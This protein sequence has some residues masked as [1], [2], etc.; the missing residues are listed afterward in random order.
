MHAQVFIEYP[1]SW[2]DRTTVVIFP[3]CIAESVA[4]A[5]GIAVCCL[6]LMSLS[7]FHHAGL[8]KECGKGLETLERRN[9]C[10]VPSFLSASQLS[11]LNHVAHKRSVSGDQACKACISELASAE[12]SI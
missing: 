8:A 6:Q 9:E 1:P 10:G 11:S 3:A 5:Q 4:T 7:D 2:G 12:M